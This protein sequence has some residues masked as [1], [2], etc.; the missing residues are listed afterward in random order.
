[1]Y[2]FNDENIL[3]N[4]CFWSIACNNDLNTLFYRLTILCIAHWRRYT[5][6]KLCFCYKRSVC[7][8]QQSPAI[9]RET[10]SGDKRSGDGHCKD[11]LK[12]SVLR[13]SKAV[14]LLTDTSHGFNWVT[15]PSMLLYGLLSVVKTHEEISK[16]ELVTFFF[17]Q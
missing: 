13:D 12:R 1:M 6:Q 14:L 8:Y 11:K 15:G 4:I 5:A 3:N 2:S 10:M 17:L 16:L 7:K 9:V